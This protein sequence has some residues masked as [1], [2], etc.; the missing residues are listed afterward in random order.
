[1]KNRNN[2]SVFYMTIVIIIVFLAVASGRISGN[3]DKT[4]ESTTTE[5]TTEESVTTEKDVNEKTTAE[6]N[7]QVTTT[8]EVTTE[9]AV[10]DDR[11]LVFKSKSK[12]N[13]HYEKHGKEMGF[14]S[15]EDYEAAAKKVVL[16]K[17]SLHKL[18]ERVDDQ[19][20]AIGESIYRSFKEGSEYEDFSE[21]FGRIDA[22][23]DEIDELRT[24]IANIKK[25]DICP[26]CNAFIN[27]DKFCSKCGAKLKK[28]EE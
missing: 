16:N 19:F 6:D 23:N 11:P 25:S 28:D 8:E 9:E 22:L 17:N 4:T 2:N 13:D 10:K 7:T 15:A 18:E 27:T 3:K 24:K 12:L 5:I 21:I 26:N 20:N 1:M 14:S